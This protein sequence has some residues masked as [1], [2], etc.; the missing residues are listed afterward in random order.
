MILYQSCVKQETQNEATQKQGQLAEK[1][2]SLSAVAQQSFA[3][4]ILWKQAFKNDCT[5]TCLACTLTNK[6]QCNPENSRTEFMELKEISEE[7]NHKSKSRKNLKE[8]FRGRKRKA[9]FNL[10]KGQLFI[11]SLILAQDERWRRA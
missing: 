7:R 11:E 1:H 5:K 8:S 9:K 4:N 6:Q 10:G 3:Q 2:C